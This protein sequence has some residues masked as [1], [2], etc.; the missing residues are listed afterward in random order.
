MFKIMLKKR[1]L[2]GLAVIMTALSAQATI[3]NVKDFGAK[4]D[5]KT[6]DTQ[7]IQNAID[8]AKLRNSGGVLY[9]PAGHYLISKTLILDRTSGLIV[10]GEGAMGYKAAY[11][12]PQSSQSAL[13]WNGEPGGTLFHTQGC[14]G[15]SYESLAFGGLAPGKV[16]EAR[17]GILFLIT[18][19]KGAGNMVHRFSHLSF[20]DAAVG[21]Q[22]GSEKTQKT[23]DS[24]FHL[25]SICFGN[26]DSGFKAFHEQ[27]VD[28]TFTFV[29]GLNCGTVFDFPRGG[30]LL[31]NTAQLTNCN[32]LSVGKCGFNNGLFLLNNVRLEAGSTYEK[33]GKRGQ[34][35][36][37]SEDV[38][39]AIV[40]FNSYCD[41]QWFWFKQ[42]PQ[43][44]IPLCEINGGTLVEFSNSVFQG[45]VATING[46]AKNKARLIIRNSGFRFVTPDKAVNA[47][48]YGFYR[49]VDNVDS[50]MDLYPDAVKW[51]LPGK[52]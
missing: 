29:F 4:G 27:A 26:L 21:I 16:R 18:T 39:F 44:K 17:A 11:S 13:I 8:K 50:S 14:F 41:A 3:I 40:R 43:P 47:N 20:S 51:P 1:M 2:A 10:R 15:N 38:G 32:V 30:N 12:T 37:T 23:N 6:D 45:P 46:K 28:Y 34:L 33:E 49:L 24:D 25:E 19:V 48:E 42:K 7:A 35:L 22:T 36:K 52:K 9:L 31:V 5:G